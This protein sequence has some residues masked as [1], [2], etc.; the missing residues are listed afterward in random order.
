MEP[1]VPCPRCHYEYYDLLTE[2][3]YEA[4]SAFFQGGTFRMCRQM[5]Y[6]QMDTCN[7]GCAFCFPG[8]IMPDEEITQRALRVF[9]RHVRMNFKNR[10]VFG[11][12]KS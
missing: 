3:D 5:D 4:L 6:C 11:K 2:Q 7:P 12:Y 8:M 9:M 10:P 1:T